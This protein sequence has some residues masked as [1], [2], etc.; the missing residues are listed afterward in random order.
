MF[1]VMP[2]MP[3]CATMTDLSRGPLNGARVFGGVR[4]AY[5]VLAG[6]PSFYL[7]LL[8]VDLIPSLALDILLLPLTVCVL[9]LNV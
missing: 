1:G 2:V 5:E 8:P 7:P 3:G 4:Y 9:M 6:F